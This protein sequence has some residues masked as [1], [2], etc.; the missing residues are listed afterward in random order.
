MLR[1]WRLRVLSAAL[2]LGVAAFW[3][4]AADG[5][6]RKVQRE[7]ASKAEQ[8][9]N[10]RDAYET[11]RKLALDPADDASEVGNDLTHAINCLQNLRR[12]DE[13]DDFRE[14]VIAAHKGNWRLLNTAARTYQEGEHLG[15]I[16][17]G[18]FSRGWRRAGGR[19]VSSVYRDRVR[20]LQLM[21]QALPL[22]KNE[23]DRGSVASY[24]FHFA[25]VFLNGA[26]YY[27]KWR[28]QSLTD[29]AQLPDYGEGWGYGGTA[30]GAPVE[31]NGEPVYYR[32]PKS[33]EASQN[34]GQ[35]WRWMLV[36]A[37]E[38][39][40]GRASEADMVLANFVRGQLGV[41]TMAQHGRRFGGGSDK[42]DTSGTYALHTLTDDETI[43]RLATGTKRF[44]VP[45]EFNWI[46]IYERVVARGKH[47][48]GEQARDALAGEYEDRRQYVRSA[49]A[50]KKAIDEYGPGQNNYRQQRLDQIVGNWGRFEPGEVQPAGAKA[51]A[52]FRYR[53]G[54][55]VSFEARPIDVAKL[56]EDVKSYLKSNPGNQLNGNKINIQNIGYRLVAENETGYLGEKAAAWDMG[57]KPPAGHVD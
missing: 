1:N 47:P 20:A 46:K 50:W 26:G 53:N 45:D 18:K 10:F 2:V 4:F 9:G 13:T 32:V 25:D 37:V 22:V 7:S 52:D 29:L 39:D 17:A 12:D 5:T 14:G 15:Y 57:L 36:Q 19:F 24:Y 30:R 42:E 54:N 49:E 11:F 38:H 56:L 3:L 8:Q 41:Q 23:K 48:N 6:T 28:L 31:A 44:K 55:K 35:R 21:R 33:Y 16:I 34:D 51:T 43:A 27:E 40:P